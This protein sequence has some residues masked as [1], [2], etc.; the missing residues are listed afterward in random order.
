LLKFLLSPQAAWGQWDTFLG[1]DAHQAIRGTIWQAP[2]LTILDILVDQHSV[3]F[4]YLEEL[5][6]VIPASNWPDPGG[7]DVKP[8]N[9]N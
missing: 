3:V 8:L 6:I 5:V 9:E 2:L 4:Q 1:Q 7:V